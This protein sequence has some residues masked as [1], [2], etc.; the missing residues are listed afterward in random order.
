MRRVWQVRKCAKK[1][2]TVSPPIATRIQLRA[3]DRSLATPPDSTTLS[4][5][6]RSR[7]GAG[8]KTDGTV[9]DP[10]GNV[11][12]AHKLQCSQFLNSPFESNCISQVNPPVRAQLPPVCPAHRWPARLRKVALP[13]NRGASTGMVFWASQTPAILQ[14]LPVPANPI[15]P[16]RFL[17]LIHFRT[18]FARIGLLTNLS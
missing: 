7:E 18:A 13:L 16:S 11:D 10:V 1:R 5:S 4:A 9:S 14:I 3:A 12:S 8:L 15:C 17:L 6:C 2:Q